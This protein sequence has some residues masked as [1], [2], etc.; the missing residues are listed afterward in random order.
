MRFLRQLVQMVSGDASQFNLTIRLGIALGFIVI[1][2]LL[3]AL[4]P[5]FVRWIKDRVTVFGKKH[6]RSFTIRKVKI[7]DTAQILEAVYFVLTVFKIALVVFQLSI[8]IPLVFSLFTLTQ[9]LAATL[10]DYILTP[11]KTVF[12]HAIGY[13]PNLITIAIF[14]II[15]KYV[16]RSFKFFALRIE[17]GKLVIPGFYSEWALPTFNIL[18]FVIYAFTTAIIY[19]YLP[20]SDSRAFQGVSVFVG[21]IVSFG[22]SSAIGNLVAGIVLTYMRP[23]KV[24][25]RIMIQNITGFVVEKSLLITRLRT[26]KNEYVTFPNTMVLNASIVNYHI[27]SADDESALLLYAEITFNYATP[28]EIIHE[29]LIGAALKTERVLKN[30]KPF[31]LQTALDD[32]YAHYQI[33]AYIREVDYAPAIYSQLFQN[34]QTAFREAGLDMTAPHFRINLD[35]AARIP[36]AGLLKNPESPAKKS[37][38]NA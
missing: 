30:P 37:R 8:S 9:N 16:I 20:G 14:I 26:H 17:K 7:L 27:S 38:R 5:V 25:D 31:V 12:F 29:L 2:V 35:E 24:G 3:I 15:A 33:N 36:P 21:I 4:T 18:R 19:P 13:I 11:L 22:S 34:I 28:W 23:F 6:V 10:F 1:Q 32:F